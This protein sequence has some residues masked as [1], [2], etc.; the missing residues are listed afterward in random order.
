MRRSWGRGAAPLAQPYD[1]LCAALTFAPW[2]EPGWCLSTVFRLIHNGWKSTPDSP[3]ETPGRSDLRSEPLRRPPEHSPHN[4]DP[5][6]GPRNEQALDLQWRHPE[7]GHQLRFSY[8]DDDGNL[9]SIPEEAAATP[10][11]APRPVGA[12]SSPTPPQTARGRPSPNGSETLFLIQVSATSKPF[13]P[14]CPL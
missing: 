7:V 14:F 5:I 10:M 11:A 8:Y 12:G 4:A 3:A 9:L 1:V 6:A 2:S 13:L